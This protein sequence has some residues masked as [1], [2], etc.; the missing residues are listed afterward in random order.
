MEEMLQVVLLGAGT[1]AQAT[2][3]RAVRFECF[4]GGYIHFLPLEPLAAA[5]KYTL[6]STLTDLLQASRPGGRRDSTSKPIQ[7]PSRARGIQLGALGSCTQT[8][9]PK[10]FN[11]D[12]L[13]G[14]PVQRLPGRF[15]AER[16]RRRPVF[17]PRSR[18]ASAS[19]HM[20]GGRA[21]MC[22]SA[23]TFSTRVRF[24]RSAIPFNSGVSCTVSRVRSQRCEVF[25]EFITQVFSPS[26][27]SQ[28]FDRAAVTL[29]AR[30]RLKPFV[31]C[32]SVALD[33]EEVCGG[34]TGCII[35]EGDV[36]TSSA[37]GGHWGPPHIGVDFITELFCLFTDSDLWDRL[38]S[39]TRVDARLAVLLPRI[40]VER[41]PSDKPS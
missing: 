26:I 5:A 27:G 20:F 8:A 16:T 40:R 9:S 11:R 6:R 1:T 37:S 34:E 33:S 31:G 36:V 10:R 39:G 7:R 22:S 4:G 15:A 35:R 21:A 32:E 17:Q 41:D 18:A 3:R 38:P 25:I 28:D 30:P 24:R 13:G 12:K 14:V 29:C 19:P 2:M 23:R